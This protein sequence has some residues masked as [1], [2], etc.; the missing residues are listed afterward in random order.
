MTDEEW[1]AVKLALEQERDAARLEVIARDDRILELER[2]VIQLEGELEE[3]DE[4]LAAL[5]ELEDQLD[6]AE[7]ALGLDRAAPIDRWMALHGRYE[8]ARR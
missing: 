5:T 1:G 8:R 7:R 6:D 3:R 2:R 4:Q